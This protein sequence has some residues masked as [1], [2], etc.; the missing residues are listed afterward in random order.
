MKKRPTGTEI[1][2]PMAGGPLALPADLI[3]AARDYARAAHAPRTLEAY[4]SAW[5]SF[6][7][8]CSAKG[9][10]ALPAE[11]ETVA[12]WMAALARGEGGRKP[13]A[14]SSINLMLSAVIVRHRDAG[15]AF[16]RKHR[17]IART[18]K[19]ISNTKAKT[20]TK[21]QARPLMADDLQALLNSLR[22]TVPAEARDAAVLA[23]GW[24]AAL[25]RSE[26]VGLDWHKLGDGSGFVTIDDRGVVV[27]LMASKASQ[28]QAETIIVPCA[29]MPAAC[30]ALERWAE[31]AR[32]KSGQPVFR[33]VDQ[34]QIIGDERLAGRSVSRIVKA[35]VRK[36]A[37][38]R[39]KS[40]TEAD[41]LVALFSGHSMRAGYATSAAARDMPGYRIQQHT[42]HKS[43]EM[44]AGYIREADKWTK[45]GLKGVGF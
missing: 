44:V 9:L 13:L 28:D 24:A 38:L 29:D 43:A 20:E 34:R 25:R 2:R 8:W 30:E 35:R 31:V 33:S 32:L 3:E 22:P 6:K 5:E 1:I 45:S 4:E 42:R 21:R 40:E 7:D 10:P 23:L 14:R 39:G 27:T 11:P 19:G 15:Y 41:E 18:W 26:L 12:V 36:L 37:R 17:A 16:D